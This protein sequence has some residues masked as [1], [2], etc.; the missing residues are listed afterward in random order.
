MKNTFKGIG[1]VTFIQNKIQKQNYYQ[2][3]LLLFKFQSVL[4]GTGSISPPG[5]WVERQILRAHL[6]L[7][8]SET[9]GGGCLHTV[10]SQALQGDLTVP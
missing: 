5:N 4:Q 3:I 2:M 7:T 8:E 9:L 10:F 1:K 6:R